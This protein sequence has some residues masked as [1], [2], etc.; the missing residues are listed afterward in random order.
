MSASRRVLRWLAALVLLVVVATV[1]LVVAWTLL[2]GLARGPGAQYMSRLLQR[3]V[4]LESIRL[5][6][7]ELAI[8]LGGLKVGE[9]GTSAVG[10]GHS[11]ASTTWTSGS[12]PSRCG[13]ALRSSSRSS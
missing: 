3:P 13:A 4:T 1:A 2:P 11:R 6:P 12:R 10:T 9:P 8:H 5:E 7:L